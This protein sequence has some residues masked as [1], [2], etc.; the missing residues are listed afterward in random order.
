MHSPERICEALAWLYGAE[1]DFEDDVSYLKNTAYIFDP[2]GGSSVNGQRLT[3]FV[4]D[5][6]CATAA[7]PYRRREDITADLAHAL[8]VTAPWEWTRSSTGH[9]HGYGGKREDVVSAGLYEKT[10]PVPWWWNIGTMKHEDSAPNV[11]AAK[12]AARAAYLTW[13]RGLFA[14]KGLPNG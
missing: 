6:G 3:I 7:W 12:T 13:M 1:F 8:A 4:R 2:K 5:D 14:M 9:W 10:T 11:D